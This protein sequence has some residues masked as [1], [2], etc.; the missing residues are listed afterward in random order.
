M[1]QKKCDEK[2]CILKDCVRAIKYRVPY[3]CIYVALHV[4]IHAY[5]YIIYS[6]STMVI[7]ISIARNPKHEFLILGKR[8]SRIEIGEVFGARC[9]HSHVLNIKSRCCQEQ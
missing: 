6:C 9:R 8:V 7:P 3:F 2:I 4:L 5:I 1:Y